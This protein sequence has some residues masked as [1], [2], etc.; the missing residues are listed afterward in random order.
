METAEQLERE[1]EARKKA[2]AQLL[3][4]T[5]QLEVASQMHRASWNIRWM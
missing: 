3:L 2:E 5:R 1:I 4:V